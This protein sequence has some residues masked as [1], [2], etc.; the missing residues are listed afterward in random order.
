MWF[1]II[2]IL[3]LVAG[4][5]TESTNEK[6]S[7]FS[8]CIGLGAFSFVWITFALSSSSTSGQIIFGINSIL[9]PIMTFIYFK[10]FLK[11]L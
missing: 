7:D 11:K 2:G 10:S 8:Y 6:V 9:F 5:I 3:G 4:K 1:I